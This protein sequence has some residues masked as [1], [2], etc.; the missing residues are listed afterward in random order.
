MNANEKKLFCRRLF[1]D[2]WNG[3]KIELLPDFH[4]PDFVMTDP[5]VPI[6]G[7]GLEAAKSYLQMLKKAFPD[8]TLK[9]DEQIAEGDIVVTRMSVTGTHEGEFLGLPPTHTKASLPCIV[10]QRFAGDKIA[11]AFGLWDA[12]GFMRAAG[13]AE[14][15]K[16]FAYAKA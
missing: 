5:N 7:K 13:A 9:I 4:T 15:P 2:V 1:E 10:I 8:L 11:E 16:A 12:L 14:M 6:T 3:G